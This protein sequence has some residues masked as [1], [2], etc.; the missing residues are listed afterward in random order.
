[1]LSWILRRIEDAFER[2]RQRRDLLAL[3][4]DQL[5]DIG[6]SRSMAHREASRP[7]WK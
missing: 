7:F 4:D 5:K 1:M 6:I 3:S 2:R